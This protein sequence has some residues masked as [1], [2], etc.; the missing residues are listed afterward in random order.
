MGRGPRG[1]QKK[2]GLPPR[3][4]LLNGRAEGFYWEKIFMGECSNKKSKRRR[5]LSSG[6]KGVFV[7]RGGSQ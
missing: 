1:A 5:N 3:V 6:K 7:L 4:K 2:E